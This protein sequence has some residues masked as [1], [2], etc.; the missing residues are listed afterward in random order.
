MAVIL[1]NGT[2]YISA[3]AGTVTVI[4]YNDRRTGE[5]FIT[6]ITD[7]ALSR[8]DA[9]EPIV[10]ANRANFDVLEDSIRGDVEKNYVKADA[11]AT[12][13][14]N[15]ESS[16]A[17]TAEAVTM[18]FQSTE[19]MVANVNNQ[20]L[21]YKDD[22]SKYIRFS[23]E[24]IEI[25]E[26]GNALTLKVD[27]DEIGFYKEGDQIAYWDGSTLY[28]GNAWITLERQFR[29]GNF[30]AIPRSDGSVSWLKVGE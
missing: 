8:L 12:Y 1:R 9:L 26:E 23:E 11:F 3:D 14:Q 30:A 27:N 21:T 5:P 10:E 22:I 2:N 24:G 15:L 6:S 20:L 13:T 16:I 28:T 4:Y 17:Q 29:V 7:D 25:G 19:E 18:R